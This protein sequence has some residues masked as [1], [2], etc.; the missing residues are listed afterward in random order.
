MDEL[1]EYPRHGIS[2]IVMGSDR[3]R[4]HCTPAIGNEHLR[5]IPGLWDPSSTSP[6]KKSHFPQRVLRSLVPAGCRSD[7]VPFDAVDPL[8]DVT[9]RGHRMSLDA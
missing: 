6:P 2:R 7:Q 3:I 5:G 4:T 8:G 1:L 9:I